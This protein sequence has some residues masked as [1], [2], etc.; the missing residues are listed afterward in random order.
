MVMKAVLKDSDKKVY[1]QRQPEVE[2]M[3]GIESDRRVWHLN[4]KLGM[5]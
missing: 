4:E 1:M 5:Y 2:K 3:G